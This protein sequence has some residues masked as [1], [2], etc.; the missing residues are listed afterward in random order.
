[1]K[2]NL[3]IW[4]V[5]CCRPFQ[6]DEEVVTSAQ[7]ARFVTET[8]YV[9]EAEKFGWSFVFEGSASVPVAREC[10]QN[11]GRVKWVQEEEEVEEEME[12]EARGGGR[13]NSALLYASTII[14]C[15]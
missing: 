4:N 14:L 13:M 11:M 10:D 7:F 1:M 15:V 3:Y 2:W 6:I 12:D 8:A 5:S 9:T